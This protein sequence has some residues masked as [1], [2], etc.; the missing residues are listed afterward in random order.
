MP[1]HDCGIGTS[2]QLVQALKREGDDAKRLVVLREAW[3]DTAV[4]VPDKALLVADTI[5]DA[6][7]RPGARCEHGYWALLEHALG[8]DVVPTLLARHSVLAIADG[9]FA[10]CDASAFRAAA[11][12][13]AVLLPPAVRRGTIEGA[14]EALIG[15]LRALPRVGAGRSVVLDAFLRAW[16]PLVALGANAKKTARAFDGAL[17]VYA[18][19][20]VHAADVREQLEHL[21]L[22]AFFPPGVGV[23]ECV[24]ALSARLGAD[25]AAASADVVAAAPA[26]VHLAVQ[27]Q[28]SRE[29]ILALLSALLH[30]LRA[31]PA[32]RMHTAQLIERHALYVPGGAD[33]D[34]WRTLLHQLRTDTL[35]DVHSHPDTAFATLTAL[36]LVHADSFQE[37][38]VPAATAAAEH[39][40]DA[41][42]VFCTC[43]LERFAHARSMPRL[44]A[45]LHCVAEQL[46]TRH[47]ER[48]AHVLASGALLAHG[49][50]R[51]EDALHVYTPPPQAPALV[52]AAVDGAAR[53]L[54]GPPGAFAC[55]AFLLALVVR[56]V[57]ADCSAAAALA[58]A[59]LDCGLTAPG[60]RLVYALRW[61]RHGVSADSAPRAAPTPPDGLAH[62]VAHAAPAA[63]AE[64]LRTALDHRT[65][66]EAC[67]A[68]ALPHITAPTDPCHTLLG[69]AR[70]QHAF[71]LW[72]LVVRWAHVLDAHPAALRAVVA[73]LHDTLAQGG[74]A[75]AE[76]SL[77]LLRSPAFHEMHGWRAA[78]LAH[79]HHALRGDG[80]LA[81]AALLDAV[82]PAYIGADLL[83]ALAALDAHVAVA[84]GD[85]RLW[86]MLHGVLRRTAPPIDVAAYISGTHTNPALAAPD[87]ALAASAQALVERA[88]WTL[89]DCR[90]A[91]AAADRL[92]RD[93]A[94]A[95]I[96]HAIAAV[97]AERG[98][99]VEG[100]AD[101]A[102]A[103]F[104]DGSWRARPAHAL[105]VRA[106][107]AE[108][109]RAPHDV[110]AALTD[111]LAQVCEHEPSVPLVSAL[112][113][114]IAALQA[115]DA[116]HTSAL[117]AA[118]ALA[119]AAL[120]AEALAPL[121]PVVC[122]AF[123]RMDE[124]T[125]R[126]ALGALTR[127]ATAGTPAA[128][129]VLSTLGLALHHGPPGT[130]RTARDALV[131]LLAALPAALD[132]RLAGPAAVLLERICT[133]RALLLRAGDVP[134]IMHVISCI[135]APSAHKCGGSTAPPHVYLALVGCMGA[136]VRLRKDL[137]SHYLPHLTQVL[138]ELVPLLTSLADTHAGGAALRE[139]RE[140]TPSWADLAT[141]PLGVRE[142]QALGRLLGELPAKS[143]PL[144]SSA[145][146]HKRRRVDAGVQSL[147][148]AM[149]KHA[150]YVLLAYVRCV[151][152]VA[153]TIAP[154]LRE[155]L[156]PGL[157]ALCSM[158][159]HHERDAAL[160]SLLDAP[161]QLVFKSIWA[162][163]ER[164]RYRGA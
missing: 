119:D 147:A 7:R 39:T 37:H 68:A 117:C 22:H 121:A 74:G 8:A 106:Y 162:D 21:G 12:A 127:Q 11:P 34:T 44:L 17:G 60:L 148:G 92:P 25:A 115:A 23:A 150:I 38:L 141:A 113:A 64:A 79:V 41:A 13:L 43:V 157:M 95:H 140:A 139:L 29:H 46:A 161:G 87:P 101:R 76:L 61:P 98:A 56:N 88:P 138:C 97:A 152:R 9:F 75:L 137:V 146:A 2:E 19:A 122:A 4:F 49:S 142:A 160:K 104:R 134:R 57:A 32:A 163:W 35:A 133:A 99:H 58:R 123:A 85:A 103:P 116:R 131:A 135:L 3:H 107:V 16:T 80:A 77:T 52:D 108:L 59:A 63:S 84:G 111:A 112:L 151:T 72:R 10:E 62:I 110:S 24:E 55:T 5:L 65:A 33:S 89:T 118:Y 54:D 120:P 70:S 48:A 51:L 28:A 126:A 96:M 66:V 83:P 78:V 82:P 153:T 114:G 1:L 145:I 93:S 50:R 71:A 130:S 69:L 143:A 158:I 67:I 27:A 42:A 45:I 128:P 90:S 81:A 18:A 53:H 94:G 129:A 144:V 156:H 6:L 26:F 149:S 36:W 15:L 14:N 124:A 154:P 47:G 86:R 136:L 100:I 40:G 164:Q 31:G 30:L 20:Y 109:A 159:S 91:L 105:A 125:Y 102:L 155:A 132:A 73:R